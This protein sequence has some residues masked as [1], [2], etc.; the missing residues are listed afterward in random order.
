MKPTLNDFVIYRPNIDSSN[1]LAVEWNSITL[2]TPKI[3]L[4][5]R[6]W[7]FWE[8]IPLHLLNFDGN[9]AEIEDFWLLAAKIDYYESLIGFFSEIKT[10]Y[11]QIIQDQ[12]FKWQK[13]QIFLISSDKNSTCRSTKLRPSTQIEWL[14]NF[15]TQIQLRPYFQPLYGHC[16]I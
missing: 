7:I 9:K 4:N 6:I 14:N 3:V 13:H 10:N 11:M 5:Q 2:I 16:P 8:A 15:S 12:H 1:D